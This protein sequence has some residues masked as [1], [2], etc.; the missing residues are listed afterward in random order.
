MTNVL[1]IRGDDYPF[2]A[3]ASTV[4]E[5]I[6]GQPDLSSTLARDVSVL[7]S[8]ELASY[9]VL[10]YGGRLTRRTVGPD[11]KVTW[12][13]MLSEAEENGLLSFVRDGKGLVGIHY[14]S[15]TLPGHLGLLVGGQANW[16][17]PLTTHQVQIE[18]REHPI[19]RGV[20]DFSVDDELYMLAW[21]PSVHV[22]AIVE[23]YEKRLPVAWTHAYGKGRVFYT[24]LGHDER[25]FATPHFLRML[26]NATRWAAGE[27][28]AATASGRA[29]RGSG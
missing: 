3:Y 7:A 23:W 6:D 11:G 1:V 20:D 25:A 21:D 12:P 27:P 5:A 13:P 8:P 29:G 26:L 14:M 24:S 15:W 9:D 10:V 16:H 19:T 2:G 18:D 17:P 22:L 4:H 28:T